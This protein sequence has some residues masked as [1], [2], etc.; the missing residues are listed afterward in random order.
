MEALL[1]RIVVVL[2]LCLA[3]VAVQAQTGTETASPIP[4]TVY[5]E[6]L[7]AIDEFLSDTPVASQT[8]APASSGWLPLPPVSRPIVVEPPETGKK[9]V[10]EGEGLLD[11]VITT[12]REK[13]PRQ[14]S[15]MPS[16]IE[17]WTGDR[18]IASLENG[19]PG[20]ENGFH[21]R[22]FR[23]PPISLPA[24]YHFLTIRGFAEGFVSREQKWKGRI[25]QVGIHD[26]KT[27]T[28]HER[29]PMFVW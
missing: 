14:I 18:M 15:I 11:V 10:P 5:P 28:L 6:S 25:I 17:I 2:C 27:T 9:V 23:F 7:N 8:P 12:V 19:E 22:V 26:G 29:L 21:R 4:E 3:A 13:T 24:G 1:R 16:R 20:V